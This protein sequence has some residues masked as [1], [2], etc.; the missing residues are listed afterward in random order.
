MRRKLFHALEDLDGA[1]QG[2]G[3]MGLFLFQ[4]KQLSKFSQVGARRQHLGDVSEDNAASQG[5]AGHF[6]SP[7]EQPGSVSGLV[8]DGH[9]VAEKQ[10]VIV[11]G[12]AKKERAERGLIIFF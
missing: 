9:Q 2:K 8:E 6:S 12:S 10:H 1:E 5:D 4:S 11:A 7:L 3:K